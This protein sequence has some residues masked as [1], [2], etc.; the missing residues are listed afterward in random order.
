MIAHQEQE[1][2]I[3][4][5]DLVELAALTLTPGK[6][7]WPQEIGGRCLELELILSLG[8]ADSVG[9]GVFCSRDLSEQTTVTL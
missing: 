5:R 3:L 7:R 2:Q 4:R 6:D 8:D 9:V 1:L